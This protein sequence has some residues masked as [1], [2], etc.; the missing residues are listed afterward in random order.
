[1]HG[2]IINILAAIALGALSIWAIGTIV[3]G[4]QEGDSAKI[5][6]GA[7]VSMAEITFF[8]IYVTTLQPYIS[9]L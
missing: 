7:L 5:I 6:R 1:M 2:I 8:I 9:A 4:I 3:M